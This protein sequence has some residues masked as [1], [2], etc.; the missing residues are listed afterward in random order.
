MGFDLETAQQ[1]NEKLEVTI[2]KLT[3]DIGVST[4]KIEDLTATVA[5]DDA[6]LKAAT[7]VRGKEAAD[8]TAAETELAQGVDFLGRAIG[9]ILR[10]RE[11]GA[12]DASALVRI[13]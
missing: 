2:G 11:K 5:A 12:L 13:S 8:F 6:D 9:Y 7:A 3:S 10:E 1:S 4:Q